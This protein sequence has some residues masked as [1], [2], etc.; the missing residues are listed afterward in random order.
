MNCTLTTKQLEQ[1]FGKVYKDLQK[2]SQS[3]DPFSIK[4]Y[5]SDIHNLILEK[6]EDPALALSYAQ[7]I[8]EFIDLALTGKRELVKK[9]RKKGLN[10]EE[11]ADTIDEFENIDK[12]QD[13]VGSTKS[14]VKE[15]KETIDSVAQDQR[16]ATVSEP[17]SPDVLDKAAQELLEFIFKAVTGLSTTGQQGIKE[18]LETYDKITNIKNPEETF[19][20]DFFDE[21]ATAMRNQSKNSEEVTIGGNTGFKLKMVRKNQI[22][23]EKARPYEQRLVKGEETEIDKKTKKRIPISAESG[24]RRYYGGVGAVVTNN[25]G[26]IL[27]FD[28]KYN[29]VS[30]ELGKPIYHNIRMVYEKNGIYSTGKEFGGTE[31]KLQKK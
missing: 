22:A 17:T 7:Q 12:V 9:L 14:T 30:P 10:L 26:E 1:L 25:E 6:T 13:A 16:K 28:D 4:G 23:I 8:P 24:Q 29:V 18:F 19:Y 31:Y 15:I 2:L 21:F 11:L 20:Y 27:Y 3:T 5:A